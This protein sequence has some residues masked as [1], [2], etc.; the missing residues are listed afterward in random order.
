MFAPNYH[1]TMKYV[2]PIRKKIGTRTIFNL[3]GPLS[4][5]ANVKDKLQV[6]FQK[7]G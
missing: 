3:L 5:P 2:A 4:S 6:F 1:L 7:S